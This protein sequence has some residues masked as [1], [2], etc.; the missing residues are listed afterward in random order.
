[1]SNLLPMHPP[2]AT[3][4]DDAWEDL[5]NYIEERRVIPI[6]GP[7]LLKI[8]TE[9]GPRLLYDWVAEKLAG[10]LNVDTTQLPQPYTLNDVVCWFLSSRGRREEAYTRVR[11]ILRDANFAPPLA[12]RQLAQITDFDLFVTTT[13]DPLLEQAINAERFQG[14]QS[15]EVIAYTPNRVADLP[16]EREKLQRPVIYHLLGRLSASPTYVISD[17]DTLEFI[18]ALQSEHL[19]PEKLFH[20]LEHNH[21]LFIGSNFTNWLARLFLRMAKRHRLSDPRD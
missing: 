14:A 20:E 18:C 19:T 21:L 5:L 4:D 9:T 8:E 6:I 11:S 16:S 13:F 15:T 17:E 2:L 7:E 10:K 1:M 3:L 12:L